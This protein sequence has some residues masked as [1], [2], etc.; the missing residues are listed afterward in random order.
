MLALNYLIIKLILI[1]KNNLKISLTNYLNIFYFFLLSILVFIV[2]VRF[3]LI[4]S[5]HNFINTETANQYYCYILLLVYI[6][7]HNN[8]YYLYKNLKTKTNIKVL[9]NIYNVQIIIYLLSFLISLLCLLSLNFSVNY[10]SIFYL[11][12][13]T[14][15][16]IHITKGL[17]KLESK[18]YMLC[19]IY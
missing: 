2:F 14:I 7:M 17:S 12:I 4:N 9:T 15:C 18:I 3:N 1:H 19:T 6:C 13:I 16:T 11:I 5:I 10:K 8:I